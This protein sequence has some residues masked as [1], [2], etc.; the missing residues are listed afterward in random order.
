MEECKAI[1]GQ[2]IDDLKPLPKNTMEFNLK[3]TGNRVGSQ[4]V[5]TF[6]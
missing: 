5:S 2:G 1:T 6:I 4:E 3:N